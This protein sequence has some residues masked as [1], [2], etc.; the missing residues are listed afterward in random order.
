MRKQAGIGSNP[1]LKL[2]PCDSLSLSCLTHQSS[3]PTKHKLLTCPPPHTPT[4]T[5]KTWCPKMG[6]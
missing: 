1:R 3:N 5:P 6:R 4:H 2:R